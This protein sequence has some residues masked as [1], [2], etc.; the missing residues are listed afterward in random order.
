MLLRYSSISSTTSKKG[1]SAIKVNKVIYLLI[2]FFLGGIG[3]HKF[4]IKKNTAGIL[5]FLFCWTGIPALLAIYD[6]VVAFL[7]KEDADGNITFE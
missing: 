3:I 1:A 2:T 4:Y 7:K 6:L 5:Y